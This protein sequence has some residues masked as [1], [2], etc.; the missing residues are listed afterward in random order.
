[1][2]VLE[3]F[4]NLV[5]RVKYLV[6]HNISFDEKVLGAEYLRNNLQDSISSKDKICTMKSTINF[7]AI[8][9]PYGYKWPKLSEL[10]YQLFNTERKESHNALADVN[11]TAKCFWKLK[12]L[13]VLNF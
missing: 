12:E 8:N 3:L 9:G 1:M 7:C 4:E 5:K 13:G 11:D 2:T 6:A 10:Y